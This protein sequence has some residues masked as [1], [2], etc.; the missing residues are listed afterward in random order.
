MLVG[1]NSDYERIVNKLIDE[2]RTALC[3]CHNHFNKLAEM[4]KYDKDCNV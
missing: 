2:Q 1:V 4:I 3:E